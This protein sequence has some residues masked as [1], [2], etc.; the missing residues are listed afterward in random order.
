M[1]LLL[2]NPALAQILILASLGLRIAT[3]VKCNARLN[4]QSPWLG[5]KKLVML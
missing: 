1:L 5:R 3:N 4:L 2:G